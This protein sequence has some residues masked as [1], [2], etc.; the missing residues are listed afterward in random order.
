MQ[1]T[2]TSKAQITLPKA[3]RMLLHLAPGDKVA[4]ASRA[5]GQLT[6]SKAT[7]P[8]FA[9]LRGILPKP[10]RTYSIDEMNQAVADAV[11]DKQLAAR[12]KAKATRQSLSNAGD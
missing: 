7:R 1:A 10:S 5:D 3:V 2:L 6:V 12:A 9:S 4:F 11:V 8:S